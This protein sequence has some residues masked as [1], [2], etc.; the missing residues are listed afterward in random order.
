MASKLLLTNGVEVNWDE[1]AAKL[2][3]LQ[4]CSVLPQTK[5]A[6]FSMANVVFQSALDKAGGEFSIIPH[7]LCPHAVLPTKLVPGKPSWGEFA[8]NINGMQL[9]C[10]SKLFSFYLFTGY[11]GLL[12]RCL[13]N[14]FAFQGQKKQ[15][16]L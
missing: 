14:L 9:P 13:M 7:V 4:T 12:L 5:E 16:T 11:C 6:I 3:P 15:R 8:N 10:R 1:L 2:K